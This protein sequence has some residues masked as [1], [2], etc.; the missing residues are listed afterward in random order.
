MIRVLRF[1]FLQEMN[2]IPPIPVL[3]CARGKW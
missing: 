3:G 2:V 1:S